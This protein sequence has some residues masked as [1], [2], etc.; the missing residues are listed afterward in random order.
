MQAQASLK[1]A[2]AARFMNFIILPFTIVTVIFVS[3]TSSEPFVSVYL[4]VETPLSFLTSLFAINTNGFPHNEE[5]EIRLPSGWLSWRMGKHS[6]SLED[7]LLTF[8]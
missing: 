7:S 2:E 6:S 5:G 4:T 8:V 1:E 3:S